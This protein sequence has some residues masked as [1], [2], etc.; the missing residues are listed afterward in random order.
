MI[1][2]GSDTSGPLFRRREGSFAEISATSPFVCRRTTRGGARIVLF[3]ARQKGRKNAPKGLMPFGFPQRANVAAL[4]LRSCLREVLHL[5]ILR[6]CFKG[7]HRHRRRT[8]QAKEKVFA[9]CDAPYFNIIYQQTGGAS[10]SPTEISTFLLSPPAARGGKM[11]G[12]TQKTFMFF[13]PAR[14]VARQCR[15][16]PRGKALARFLATSC[17][18]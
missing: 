6:R 8:R 10:P 15:G 4:S 5:Q 7:K 14:Y 11:A 12:D 2:R 13:S 1:F 16:D 9:I 3:A 18:A 17:R